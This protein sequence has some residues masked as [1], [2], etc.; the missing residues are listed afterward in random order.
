[1]EVLKIVEGQRVPIDKQTPNMTEQMI[2]QCQV[3]PAN[4]PEEIHRQQVHAMAQSAN[5]FFRAHGVRIE[6]DLIRADAQLLHLPAIEYGNNDKVEPEPNRGCELLEG[7]EKENGWTLVYSQFPY[8]I[9]FPSV[10]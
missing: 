5:P 8:L 3:L 9:P 10:L 2:R 4:L 1:M 6:S 7:E